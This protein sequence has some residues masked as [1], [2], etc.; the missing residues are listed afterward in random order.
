MGRPIN[1]NHTFTTLGTK[2][3]LWHQHCR[4]KRLQSIE[5]NVSRCGFDCFLSHFH[6]G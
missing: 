3:K 5:P 6:F 2:R 4:Q 1:T